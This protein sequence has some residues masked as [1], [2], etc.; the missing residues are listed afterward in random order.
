[1]APGRRHPLRALLLLIPAWAFGSSIETDF[2]AP[3]KDPAG[4]AIPLRSAVIEPVWNRVNVWLPWKRWDPAQPSTLPRFEDYVTEAALVMATGARPDGDMSV[5]DVYRDSAGGLSGFD[6]SHPLFNVLRLLRTRGIRPVLDLGPVPVALSPGGKAVKSVF[7][8][9]VLGP[10]DQEKHYR[11]LK[12]LFAFLQTPGMFRKSEL[13][14]WGF[15]LLR[16][17]DNKDSWNPKGTDRNAD[18]GNLDEYKKLFDCTLA[19]LR[20]AGVDAPLQPGNLLIPIPGALDFISDSWTAPLLAWLASGDNRCPDHLI[21]P[22]YRPGKDTLVLAFSAYGG[23]PGAQL[24]MDPRRLAVLTDK[25][26]YQAERHF[27]TLPV[28]ISVAEAGLEDNRL[29]FRGDGSARGAA[30]NA[31][32]IKVSQD[33]GLYRFQQWG[34]VSTDHISRF[35]EHEGIE[36]AP[37]NVMAMYRMMQG[38]RRNALVLHRD[39]FPGSGSYLDAIASGS[40]SGPEKTRHL[41]IFRYDK[42]GASTRKETVEVLASGLEPGRMYSIRHYRVDARHS[43]YLETWRKDASDSGMAL[44]SPSDACMEFQFSPGQRKLWDRRKAGYL[45]LS[46]LASFAGDSLT[47]SRADGM[48]RLRKTVPMIANSVSLIEIR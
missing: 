42:D 29:L 31:A 46:R 23:L 16:E 10:A 48:G 30:W 35:T 13:D 39:L 5:P 25:L 15:Q 19:A 27:P 28:R 9:N 8:W 32:I 33:E 17:P 37:A 7:E 43:S 41:L 20:D 4:R 45:R 24:G 38:E 3:W 11:Y 44:A 1:M 14:T 26:R 40:G 18:I 6:P 47:K 2:N 22:R 34:F 21:L 12:S 36:S